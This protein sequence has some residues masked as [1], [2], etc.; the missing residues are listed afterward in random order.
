MPE[1][2]EYTTIREIAVAEKA[3]SAAAADA[4]DGPCRVD[5]VWKAA[6]ESSRQF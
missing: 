4:V 5:P 3:A 2:G 1:S 6:S